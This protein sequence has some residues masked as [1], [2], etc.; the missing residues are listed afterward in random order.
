M[1]ACEFMCSVLLAEELQNTSVYNGVY[2]VLNANGNIIGTRKKINHQFGICSNNTCALTCMSSS[3]QAQE[4][5]YHEV[6]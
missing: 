1:V 4:S 5:V 2:I 3:A 6:H